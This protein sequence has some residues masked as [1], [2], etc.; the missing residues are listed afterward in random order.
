MLSQVQVGLRGAGRGQ[1]RVPRGAG[2][3]PAAP[4]LLLRA[5]PWSL[6]SCVLQGTLLG[7]PGSAVGIALA[8]A[9][10][11]GSWPSG[12]CFSLCPS[13]AH[14]WRSHACPVSQINKENLKKKRKVLLAIPGTK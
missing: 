6:D 13:P 5:F 8:Q 1:A 14:A 9:L 10:I 12:D 7:R 11:P 3:S 4:G 2:A